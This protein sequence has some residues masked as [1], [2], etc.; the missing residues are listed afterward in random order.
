MKNRT[1]ATNS[2][3]V[4]PAVMFDLE[5]RIVAYMKGAEWRKLIHPNIGEDFFVPMWRKGATVHGGFG[6]NGFIE[7][8][9]NPV[10]GK[11][12]IVRVVALKQAV[13]NSMDPSISTLGGKKDI[14]QVIKDWSLI[15]IPDSAK[16]KVIEHRAECVK[17]SA[18]RAKLPLSDRSVAYSSHG[19]TSTSAG[20]TA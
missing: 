16:I 1:V 2:L 19:G 13:A 8:E 11:K 5:K 18:K 6:K 3:S 20:I 4:T 12:D 17:D 15:S 10:F 7:I 14:V 9:K